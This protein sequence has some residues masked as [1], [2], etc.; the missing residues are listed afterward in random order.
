MTQHFDPRVT[1]LILTYQNV[2]RLH[3]RHGKVEIRLSTDQADSDRTDIKPC[4]MGP[5]LIRHITVMVEIPAFFNR[6]V[7]ADDVMIPDGTPAFFPVPSVDLLR[8]DIQPGRGICCMN[9]HIFHRT[10]L[11]CRIDDLR[12]QWIEF[13][14]I[15]DQPSTEAHNGNQN[16][17][18][19]FFCGLDLQS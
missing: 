12:G 15:N 6:A 2:E 1:R 4:S 9:N 7:P 18:D 14:M 16:D 11:S 5:D 10:S 8:P 17:L 19:G 3:L 13:K